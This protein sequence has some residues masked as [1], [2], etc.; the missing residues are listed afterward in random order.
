MGWGFPLDSM[1]V[2]QKKLYRWLTLLLYSCGTVNPQ[3]RALME[4]AMVRGRMTETFGRE[5]FPSGEH[6]NLFIVGGF[7]C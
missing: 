1:E 6:D 7:R 4:N 2:G 5:V 3:D